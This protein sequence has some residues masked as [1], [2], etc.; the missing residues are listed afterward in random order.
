MMRRTFVLILALI[1]F[2]NI[3]ALSVLAQTPTGISPEPLKTN[4]SA[5]VGEFYLTLSGYIAPHASIVLTFNGVFAESTVANASGYFTIP[6]VLIKKG[7]PGFC[8]D[9]ID[10]KR[11]GE[12]LTC[13]NISPAQGSIVMKDL[14]LS[15]TVGLS[16]TE[17]AEFAPVT[18]FGY[19]MPGA[20][21]TLYL[22]NGKT[23]TAYADQEGY[24]EITIEGLK[25]GSYSLYTR[26]ELKQKTSIEP[27]NKLQLKSLSQWEQFVTYLKELW[28]KLLKFL[29]NIAL[30]PLLLAIPILIL[31]II[32]LVK[33]WPKRF[34]FKSIFREKR[35]LHHKWWMGY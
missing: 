26:A 33:L 2:C 15:P 12:S 21:V 24:Y 16:R 1:L 19:S 25:A 3:L 34:S 22:S 17:I 30:W 6:D 4:V 9:A 31:I 10:F 20:L 35:P 32:L 28:D 23:L 14:F 18:A 8:L 11:L 5:K 29:K 13:F 7:L 27:T